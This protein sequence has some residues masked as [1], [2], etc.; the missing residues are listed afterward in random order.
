MLVLGRKRGRFGL[1][2]DLSVRAMLRTI[3]KV[4]Y[5]WPW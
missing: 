5:R 4:G 2:Q 1:G 3:V